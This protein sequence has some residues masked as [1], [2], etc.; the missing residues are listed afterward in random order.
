MP[1]GA[2][3]PPTPLGKTGTKFA[4]KAP[5]IMRG[6]MDRYG[7]TKEQAAGVLGNL[8]HESAGFTAYH[9]GGQAP[10][11]GGVGWAQWTG[12]RHRDFEGW[13]AA[14]HLDPTSDAASWRYLTEGD[15]ET[16]KA[17]AAVK[18][19]N[20]RR[21][22]TRA[23]HDAFERS[24]DISH[25]QIVKPKSWN[26]R[27]NFADK[28][29]AL[30]PAASSQSAATSTGLRDP[31]Q[32]REALDRAKARVTPPQ[33]HETLSPRFAD[34]RM[35]SAALRSGDGG[36][37]PRGAAPRQAVAAAAP[38]VTQHFYGNHDPALTARF[39]MLEQNREIRREQARALH[40]I[41]RVA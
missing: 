8:G 25:G 30:G 32:R 38:A 41:G 15:P 11:R 20:N 39:A 4:G 23:F 19:T 22:A 33:P 6:L 27:L 17:I 7:L 18:R 5:Q 12:S 1:Q 10:G 37:T 35:T 29:F 13:T 3:G 2:S 14:H 16:S 31:A 34:P 9:E 24:A 21:D 26:N 40:S 36:E 28:A